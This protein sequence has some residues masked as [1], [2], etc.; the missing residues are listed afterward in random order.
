MVRSTS[1][2]L[3]GKASNKSGRNG[4]SG[5]S[6][7]MLALGLAV[8]TLCASLLIIDRLIKR[9]EVRAVRDYNNNN[10]ISVNNIPG[11]RSICGM[12]NGEPFEYIDNGTFFEGVYVEGVPL[13]GKTYAQAREDISKVIEEKLNDIT[14]VVMVGD[15]S[16]ALGAGDFN[17]SVNVNELLEKAYYLG[18]ESLNDYAANYKKQQELKKDPVR[19]DITY[20]CD[21]NSITAK[22]AQI[23]KLVNTEP[24]KPYITVSQRPSANDDS[25][26]SDDSPIIRDTDTIVQTVFADNGK[27]IAYIYYNPGKNG[28]VMDQESMV[29]RIITAFDS[30][31]YDAV[32]KAD[33]VETEPEQTPSDIKDSVCLI[34][35]YTSEFDHDEK[36]MNRC[37]NVQKAA[38]IL[39]ACVVKPGQEISFNKYVG[40]RTE[41]G[42]WLRAHGIVNGRE[43]EDSPGGG[44]CQVSGT[45][46]NALLQC[47]PA[48]IKI[49]QRQH[50]SWPSTYVPIG[51]DA[52]VDTNGPDLKWRNISKDPLYIFTYADVKKGIMYVYIY[53]TPEPDGSYYENYAEIVEEI[54][55]PEPIIVNQPLWPT[56][57]ERETI[58][59]R[60]GYTAKAYLMHYDK[61]GNLIE[62][63]YLYTDKY[64]PVQ[65]EITVGT[66]DPNL[67]KPKRTDD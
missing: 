15:A 63:M 24:T 12:D 8:I 11:G 34:S 23:A 21:P 64:K 45:L 42:G 41:A 22:V 48:K 32:L 5:F 17:V 3:N 14:M 7:V 9:E 10:W 36:H 33:L 61:D 62:Q 43:Y 67:P 4:A 29:S 18:R 40:P 2:N 37:R 47:G 50:H 51:L 56:G 26:H 1:H 60:F 57:Y 20:T 6:Y 16:L 27:A 55:P 31:D 28:F 30:G 38:G 66:G 54:E 35:S 25:S 65:G 58:T 44:I 49:T 59:A 46:Y 19:F 13:G 52:T 53:G 39:N